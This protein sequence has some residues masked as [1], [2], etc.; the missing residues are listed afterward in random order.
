MEINITENTT[1][2]DFEYYIL[3]LEIPNF[4]YNRRIYKTDNKHEIGFG[5]QQAMNYAKILDVPFAFSSN[6]DGFLR[7]NMKTGEETQI[8]LEEFPSPEELW[9]QYLIAENMTEEEKHIVSQPLY[10]AKYPPRYYQQIAIE[11]TI[12]SD[13]NPI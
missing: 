4:T 11:K 9:N 6:G 13:V 2:D 5:M 12:R 10:P 8:Q 1:Y 7:K 3:D